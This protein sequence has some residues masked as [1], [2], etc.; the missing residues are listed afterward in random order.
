MLN[1]GFIHGDIKTFVSFAFFYAFCGPTNNSS[2]KAT[3]QPRSAMNSVAAVIY[4]TL[5]PT[6]PLSKAVVVEAIVN[7]ALLV[8]DSS[9]LDTIF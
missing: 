2:S 4:S 5:T 9:S 8:T 7:S 3:Y 1:V 6:S